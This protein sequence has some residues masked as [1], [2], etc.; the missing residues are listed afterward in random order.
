MQKKQ[1]NHLSSKEINTSQLTAIVANLAELHEWELEFCPL[2]ATLTGRHLFFRI[3]QRSIGDRAHLSRA[4]KD[5]MG[6]NGF[7]EKGLRNRIQQMKKE[8]YIIA[9]T[10]EDDGRSK[11]LMP[12][13]KFYEAIYWHADK[14]R[15]I[16]EKDFLMIE[17]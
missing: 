11:Y 16:F 6:G 13:E 17:K 8:G 7:T 2:L 5:L 1:G 9:V 12:T 10:A 3:A 15:R 4:L 14:V